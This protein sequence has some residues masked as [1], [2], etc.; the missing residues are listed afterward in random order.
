MNDADFDSDDSGFYGPPGATDTLRSRVAAFDAE[1]WISRYSRN[2]SWA[3]NKHNISEASPQLH[4]PYAGIP[5]AWQLTE[6][7]DDFL[8]RMPPQTTYSSEEMPWIYI[9][10][11]F[12]ERVPKSQGKNQ[13]SRGNEDEGPELENSQ[14]DHVLA[15]AVERLDIV[16]SFEA[17]SPSVKK[18]TSTITKELNKERKQA[19][20]DILMLAH[21]GNVR[22]G[23]WM[24]FCAPSDVN[25]VWAIIAKATADNTLGIAAKVAPRSPLEDPRK[26]RLIC[27]YTSDFSD[28]SDVGNVL[29]RLR[30][31]HLVGTKFQQIYYKP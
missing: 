10:N 13:F 26:D 17:S 20:S 3:K 4:N 25:E 24:L 12:I 8:R 5:Y 14:L 29:K 11:P 19:S 21:A 18:S 22:T 31:L 16:K 9:C 15:G 2:L 6:T 23:K 7:V 28:K 1:D 30:E 27:V